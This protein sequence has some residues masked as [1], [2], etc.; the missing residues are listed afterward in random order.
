MLETS[1][2]VMSSKHSKRFSLGRQRLLFALLTFSS[3]SGGSA[4]WAAGAL[5]TGGHFAGGTGAI[6]SN[7]NSLSV[8]QSTQTGIINWQSFSIGKGNSVTIANGTGATLNRVTG[9]NNPSTIAGSLRATGSVY[10]VNQAGIVVS[11]SGKVITG[12]SFVASTRDVSDSAFTAG[13]T[14]EAAGNSS[15]TVVNQGTINS[16]NGDVVLVGKS[17]NNSGSIAASKGTATLA[18]GDDVLLQAGGDDTV[19]VKSGSGNVTNTGTIAAAQAELNAVGGNVYALAVNNGGVI[20]ATGTATKDGHVYLTA[21]DD[22]TVNASVSATNADGSGGTIVATASAI[23]IGGKARLSADGKTNGGTIL[24]GGDRHGGADPAVALS[25]TAIANAKTD[26]V[27]T[28]ARISADGGA[29]GNGGNVVVWSDANTTYAGKISAKGGAKGGNG[30]FVEVSGRDKLGFTGRV[31]TAASHGTTGTLLLDPQDVTIYSSTDTNAP[32]TSTASSSFILNTTIDAMLATSNVTI[33]TSG[34]SGGSGDIHFGTNGNAF[35]NAAPLF[36]TSNNSL[37]L[38]AAQLIDTPGGNPNN[39]TGGFNP[40]SPGTLIN[41]RGRGSIN[42]NAGGSGLTAAAT[43]ITLTGDI[44]ANGGAID[45]IS[46]GASYRI[47]V[48]NGTSVINTKAKGAGTILFQ[49]DQVRL[50]TGTGPT[51][52]VSTPGEVD[53]APTTAGAVVVGDIDPNGQFANDDNTTL[54]RTEDVINITANLLVIGSTSTTTLSLVTA[55]RAGES[56]N[57]GTPTLDALAVR[58][59]KLLTG[60]AGSVTQ[61]ANT[62]IIV[63]DV[64]GRLATG[65]GGLAVETGGAI[66]LNNSFNSVGTIA[67]KQTGAGGNIA[68]TRQGDQAA[69]SV[70][71]VVGTVADISGITTAGASRTVTLAVNETTMNPAATDPGSSIGSVSVGAIAVT[72]SAGAANAISTTSLDL[73]GPGSSFALDDTS[74]AVT[75]VSGTVGSLSLHDNIGLTTTTIGSSSGIDAAGNVTIVDNGHLTIGSGAGITATGG[76]IKLEDQTFTNSDAGSAFI[77]SGAG[78]TWRVYSQNPTLDSDNGSTLAYSFVQYNAPNSYLDPFGATLDAGATG[79]G[80]IYTVAPVLKET[81]SGTFNK[82]YDGTTKFTGTLT[83]A[84]YVVTPGFG[85]INNDQI[86]FTNSTGTGPGV[87]AY[88][89]SN[90]GNNI[91]INLANSPTFTAKDPNN[92]QIF[93]YQ[94]T[95]TI[96]LKGNITPLDVTVTGTRK[97]DGTTGAP[98]TILTVSGELMGDPTLSVTGSGILASKNANTTATDI[99]TLGTLALSGTGSG[100][101]HIASGTVLVTPLDVT[102]TGTRAY[103]GTTTASGTILTVSGEIGG[104][105]TLTVTGSGTLASKNA[106]PT[107]TNI[108]NLGSLALSGTGSG[109]Y[110]LV[111]GK[112]R[113]TPLGLTLTGTRS[114]DGTTSASSTILTIN[115][116]IGGDPALTLTGSGTLASKNANPTATNISNLGSLALSGTGSGNYSILSGKVTVTP[117]DVTVSGTRAYDGTTGALGTILTVSGELM[118]DPTLSVT[119]NG[120]LA[121][122][123]ANTTATDISALGTLALSGTGSG[124]YHIASGTVL[125][126]PLD[127]TVTGTRAYDGTTTASGTILTVSGEIG[128]D[129]ALT[130]TGSG[131]L[132]GKNANPTATNISN[133]GSLALSGTGSGNYHLVSGTVLV[134]PLAVTVTGT[135]GYDGATDASGSILTVSGEIGGDP[136]L[137]VTG[138]GT[139]ANKNA[140]TTPTNISNL[141]SLG[142]SGTGSGNY[143]IASGSVTVTPI[144]LTITPDAFTRVFDGTTT[145]KT[146]YSELAANYTVM[147]LQGSEKLG[148]SGSALFLTGS[149]LFGG[150]NGTVLRNAGTYSQAEGTLALSGSGAGNYKLIFSNPTP[151]NYVITPMIVTIVGLTGTRVYDGGTDADSSILTLSHIA[152]GDQVTLTGTGVLANKNVGKETITG[153]GTLALGG[154]NAGNYEI[155]VGRPDTYVTVTKADLTVSAVTQTKLF[156]G[157]VTSTGTPTVIGLQTGDSI[158]GTLMQ[159]YGSK[160]VLGTNGSTLSVTNYS[161]VNDGN[162]GGNY[163]VVIETA[164]GTITPEDITVSAVTQTKVYD[165]TTTSTGTP[166]HHIGHALRR[167]YADRPVAGL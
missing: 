15:A 142:L 38:D 81:V 161:G 16:V 56:A 107:A 33:S 120:T 49:A 150:S 128:G 3:L 103:D 85:G 155:V 115:G 27:A 123:N 167:R 162:N 95:P 111:S 44:V 124:N 73:K 132:A 2:T 58:N 109:N 90:A 40:F 36:W 30:G 64:D 70:G 139:L 159:A 96:K 84:N 34:G 20:R 141:G 54:I 153:I 37:T 140:S 151:N 158:I 89:T 146:A 48:G 77:V 127:V 104:D 99:S 32:F 102:V 22:L 14:I 21:G 78:N 55:N 17:V 9:V 121:S 29:E 163:N 47:E 75:K 148:N 39:T 11:S 72:Q 42:F 18:A 145:D 43:V 165:G 88:A 112:V 154:A 135:R 63:D 87:A 68:F 116:E 106:N 4:A 122:K 166:D 114:Y 93:G 12:G 125:V 133:L 126:T 136:A 59:L 60:T 129:P 71:L 6:T 92:V 137:H 8:S 105:P 52:I 69:S 113:V 45:M 46:T 160:N 164:K 10:V 86:T 134:A 61:D 51:G 1:S 82:P 53:I 66:R 100:N 26:S 35:T 152:T 65:I 74:N 62:A 98:G 41:S 138:S 31:T 83:A 24:I 157:T 143:S 5:P 67:F 76:S 94:F 50:G 80:F 149:M 28:G 108:S 19:L 147:G 110:H 131:T 118:G 91:V 25:K 13:G 156:D 79:N 117:L 57:G 97:Y 101:Y 119:G 7:G 23:S 144:D 130:V